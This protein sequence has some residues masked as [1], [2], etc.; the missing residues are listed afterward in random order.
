MTRD[1]WLQVFSM[2]QCPPGPQHSLSSNFVGLDEWFAAESLSCAP[3]CLQICN[4]SPN[5]QMV[6]LFAAQFYVQ[7]F[8]DSMLVSI[9]RNSGISSPTQQTANSRQRWVCRKEHRIHAAEPRNCVVLKGRWQML[10]CLYIYT[11]SGQS[12][13]KGEQQ[14]EGW[15]IDVFW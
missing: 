4:T 9:T 12:H 6:K 13:K 1:F 11:V 7:Y 15:Q 8:S 3:S 14:W 2:N 10:W 5:Y